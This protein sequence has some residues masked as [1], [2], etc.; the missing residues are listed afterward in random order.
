M[1]RR[2]GPVRVVE[3]TAETPFQE[4]LRIMATTV[5]LVSVHTSALANAMFL[6]PGAAVVELIHRNWVWYTLD[7]S[8]KVQSDAMGDI[9]HFAW[10]A[11]EKQHGQYIN[12]RD[13]ERFGGDEWSGVKVK[14]KHV[15]FMLLL[16]VHACVLLFW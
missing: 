12:P 5:V 11:V 4:Q 14:E 7:Q 1:L 6:P 15:D 16:F 2:F 13:E 3:F 9:H 8:F 10:R